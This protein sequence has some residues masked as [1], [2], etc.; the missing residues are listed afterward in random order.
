MITKNEQSGLK[1]CSLKFF[2]CSLPLSRTS[3]KVGS[4]SE[5]EKGEKNATAVKWQRGIE[6]KVCGAPPSLQYRHAESD[7]GSLPPPTHRQTVCDKSSERA[8]MNFVSESA[9]VI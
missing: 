3:L 5:C 7:P 1:N 9:R 6:R 4:P 8:E 2:S